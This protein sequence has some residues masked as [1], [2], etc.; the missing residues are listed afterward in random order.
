MTEDP[1]RSVR[2]DWSGDGLRFSGCGT[3]PAT[4]TIQIDGDNET[5][6]GPMLALL[7]AAAGCTAADIV[8][9][10]EKMRVDLSRLSVDVDGI[11]RGEDPRRF[12]GIHL[13]YHIGGDGLDDAKAQR[14]V[15]LSVKKYCSVMHTLA[16]DVAISYDVEISDDR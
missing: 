4:P 13:R 7:L 15:S 10:L 3:H 5:A 6:P 2:L 9:M 12:E 8:L 11:R 16:P 1:K 14:A